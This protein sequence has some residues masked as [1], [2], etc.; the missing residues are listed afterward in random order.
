[1]RKIMMFVALV[2]AFSLKVM[3]QDPLEVGPD[4]YKKVFE[5]DQ[6]RVMEVTF[7]VGGKIDMHSHP[8]H[9]VYLLTDTK[10]KLTHPDGSSKDFEGKKGEVVWI[11]AESHSAENVSDSEVKALVVELKEKK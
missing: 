2:F 9:F 6:V 5:N 7:K 10:L 4:V 1:M 3:A 11:A 8:D